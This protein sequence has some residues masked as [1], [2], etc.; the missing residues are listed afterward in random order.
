VE[1]KG[2]IS[3]KD[4]LSDLCTNCWASFKTPKTQEAVLIPST[5]GG[6]GYNLGHIWKIFVKRRTSL[7]ERDLAAIR[8]CDLLN[9]SD[10]VRMMMYSFATA[11]DQKIASTRDRP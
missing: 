9:F 5:F 4:F 8:I 10:A 1:V 2:A 7:M 11:F 6:I 3:R